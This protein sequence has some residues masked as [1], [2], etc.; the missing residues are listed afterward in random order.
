MSLVH[1]Q[2]IDHK[3]RII[4]QNVEHLVIG[5]V[6]IFFDRFCECRFHQV[7]R[8]RNSIDEHVCQEFGKDKII[9]TFE[10]ALCQISNCAKLGSVRNRAVFKNDIL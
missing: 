7:V 6:K 10:V 3:V 1:K 9:L 8:F 5:G 2:I 4:N